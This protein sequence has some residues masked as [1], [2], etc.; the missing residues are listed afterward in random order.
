MQEAVMS[1]KRTI[2]REDSSE[3]RS[4][5]SPSKKAR[6]SLSH[7]SRDTGD[8]KKDVA[9]GYSVKGSDLAEEQSEDDS[10]GS[11]ED[12]ENRSEDDEDDGQDGV[13]NPRPVPTALRCDCG[14][15][16]RM[17]QVQRGLLHN[18]GEWF[19]VCATRAC[20]YRRWADGSQFLGHSAQ[21]RFNDMMDGQ[22][23]G[24]GD[25]SSDAGDD[26]EAYYAQQADEYDPS[27]NG[28]DPFDVSDADGEEM[29]REKWILDRREQGGSEYA[30]DDEPDE[31]D[32]QRWMDEQLEEMEAV[33]AACENENYDDYYF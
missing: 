13:P 15:P 12:A 22:F 21:Q 29:L 4:P 31:E 19:G 27:E 14:N 20:T 3:E 33:A 2:D 1:K 7:K 23:G 5:P 16:A 28:M 30:S 10:E 24:D 25:A 18:L 9:P 17:Q 8:E 26:Q 11:Q 32:Y 6:V